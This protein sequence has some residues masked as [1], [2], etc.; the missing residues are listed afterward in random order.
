MDD[1][2]DRRRRLRRAHVLIRAELAIAFA[3][4]MFAG[5]L[6]V[7]MPQGPSPMFLGERPLVE[8]FVPWAGVG[9]YMVGLVW[10]IRLSRPDPEAGERSWRYRD[11]D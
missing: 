3:V 1:L 8:T 5:L 6:Y 9:L 7:A 11:Y 4:P 10:M 2:K